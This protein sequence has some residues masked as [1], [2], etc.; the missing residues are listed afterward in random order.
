MYCKELFNP[1]HTLDSKWTVHYYIISNFCQLCCGKKLSYRVFNFGRNSQ[2][3]VL[4]GNS[5]GQNHL[6]TSKFRISLNSLLAPL[7]TMFQLRT[8]D[9]TNR[10]LTVTVEIG[11]WE[12][13]V[14]RLCL[15]FGSGGWLG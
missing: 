3:L 8:T 1:T 10:G 11:F 15:H 2:C 13:E 4:E 14:Y 6:Q 5:S 12:G 9:N 7:F